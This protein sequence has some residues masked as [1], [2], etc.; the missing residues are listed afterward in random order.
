MKKFSDLNVSERLIKAFTVTLE[1]TQSEVSDPAAMVMLADLAMYSEPQVLAALKRCARELKPRQFC[2]AA[3][4]ERIDDGRP[5]P[6]VAWSMV[7]KDERASVCWTT[8][9]RDAYNAAYPLIKDGDTVQARMA[10]LEAYRAQVQLARDARRPVE[11]ELS[12]GFDKDGRELVVLDA[13]EKGRI[14]MAAAKAALPYHRDDDGLNA[15][16]LSIASGAFKRLTDKA[17]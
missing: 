1:V 16:L 12:L 3:V 4:I 13:A 7:P 11:W 6:E 8:E 9:M 10:F 17:A 2:L 15:R 5:T 14:S